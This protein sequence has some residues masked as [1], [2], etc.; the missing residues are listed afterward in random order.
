LTFK[1]GV[2][3]IRNS[4][5]VDI[6]RELSA[7]GI[8]VQVYDPIADPSHA[9]RENG[10]ELARGGKGVVIDVKAGLNRSKVPANVE[11]GCL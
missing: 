7:S 11:L 2:L 4:K 1:K 6:I 5:A 10:I 3:D 8:A 9:R